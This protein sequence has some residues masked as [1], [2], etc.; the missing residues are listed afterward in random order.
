MNSIKG[1]KIKG[2]HREFC[3]ISLKQDAFVYSKIDQF[4][5][6]KSCKKLSSEEKVFHRIVIGCFFS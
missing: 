6:K 2:S 3:L 4:Y 5:F 1:Y